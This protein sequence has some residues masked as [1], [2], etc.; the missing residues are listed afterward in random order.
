M[1]LRYILSLALFFA[2]TALT[3]C[4][5]DYEAS[6]ISTTPASLQ[7]TVK[8]AAGNILS[9]APV[10]LFTDEAGWTTESTPVLERQTDAQGHVV[11]TKEELK[12][13]GY[14][15]LIASS[16]TLKAKSKTK[17]ILL[18]DGQTNIDLV[19]K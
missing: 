5:R 3:S 16:G 2:V 10:Q 13:P 6:I 12:T 19:L 17:Y 15:Y 4:E 1:K 11:F 7:V 18:T 8:D 14:F 9:N